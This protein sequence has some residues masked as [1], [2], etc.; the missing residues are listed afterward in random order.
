MACLLENTLLLAF[1]TSKSSLLVEQFQM[2]YDQLTG[3]IFK[4][5][6]E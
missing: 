5:S 1:A 6:I 4:P 2:G 3:K